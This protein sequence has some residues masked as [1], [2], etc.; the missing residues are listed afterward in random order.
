MV[1][2]A[3]G[4]FSTVIN[5]LI[6]I[7]SG[8]IAS[9]FTTL[10]LYCGYFITGLFAGFTLGF[11]FLLIYTAFASLNSIAL[12]CVIIASFGIVMT[13]MTMWWR[14]RMLIVSSCLFASAVMATSLDYF[15]EDLFI[16]Q[17]M[18]MKIF[19]NKVANLCWY[20]YVVFGLWPLFLIIGLLI[21]CLLTGKE[22][23]KETYTFVNNRS[24]SRTQDDQN[25]LIRQDYHSP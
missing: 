8:L 2:V 7:A 10:L 12:P 17:Y 22:R 24:S 9:F 23:Q 6:A 18:E 15:I 11:L 16:L 20:S 21:Q 19:Y 5:I 13:F 3:E 25:H 1:V 14:H 4:N